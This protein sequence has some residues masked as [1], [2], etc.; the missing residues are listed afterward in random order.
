MRNS[1]TV[2]QMWNR[3]L[4]L[5]DVSM[6]RLSGTKFNFLISIYSTLLHFVKTMMVSH[7]IWQEEETNKKFTTMPKKNQ[8]R[9][10]QDIFNF[11]TICKR[12]FFLFFSSTLA[13]R[14][15]EVVMKI[16]KQFFMKIW[17]IP[18]S[19]IHCWAFFSII[20]NSWNQNCHVLPWKSTVF[21]PPHDIA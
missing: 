9:C 7:Q 20:W 10:P 17:N 1:F 6:R 4:L 2:R 14:G 13:I 19:I 21:P 3:I 12:L 11:M 5:W 15:M 8:R 18:K 16:G